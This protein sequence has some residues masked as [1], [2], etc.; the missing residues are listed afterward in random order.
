[1]A[2]PQAKRGVIWIVGKGEMKRELRAECLKPEY[3]GRLVMAGYRSDDLP[4]TYSAM[5]FAMLLG[6][7]SE[8]SARAA[9]EAMA[10]GRPVIGIN[11]GAL[12]DTI[13]DGVDGFRLNDND[14]QG[15]ADQ[16]KQLMSDRE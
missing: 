14:V 15:L 5:D 9:L 11:K 3:D 16:P 7:G 2:L 1:I 10:A 4:E 8:G 6:L 13:A 12:R